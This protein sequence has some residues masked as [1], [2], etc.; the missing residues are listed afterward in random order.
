M[1]LVKLLTVRWM[2]ATLKS[3]QNWQKYKENPI[4]INAI[5]SHHGDVEA[6]STIAVIVA[7]ADA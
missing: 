4:V 1:T 3:V 2:E 7:A 6:T 5:A